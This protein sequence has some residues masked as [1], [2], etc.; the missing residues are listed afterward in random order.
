MAKVAIL[1]FG[2]VGSGV[3]EI[4]SQNAGVCARR[5]GV[6]VEVGYICD[7]R[8]FSAHQAAGLF[9]NNIEPILQDKDVKVVVETIGGLHPAYEYVRAAL[10]SG[11][12]VVTSN[13]ELVAE[14][15]TELMR[16]AKAHSVCFLF[17]ASVGGGTPVIGPMHRDLAANHI[18]SVE[19]IVNGTTNFMLT[20]MRQAGLSFEQ[21]LA[22]A[23]ALGYAET[24]DPSAD[25]D[26]I[27]A[28]R[29]IA[30]LASLAFG[31]HVPPEA[32]PARGIRAVTPQ[33]VALAA[34]LG[35][36]VKLVA[37]AREGAPGRIEA[38][39]EPMLVRNE[40]LLSDVDDVFNAV[41]VR[42]DML[43][44]TVFYGRGAG[45][46][47]TASAVVAD[48]AEALREGA[49][50]HDTLWWAP[51]LAGGETL[52]DTRR[53]DTLLRFSGAGAAQLAA[54]LGGAAQLLWQSEG[55]C[56]FLVRAA[57]PGDVR[58]AQARAQKAGAFCEN[59]LRMLAE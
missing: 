14:K 29:K 13:K 46:L 57:A 9:V 35:C 56:A 25:V 40:D 2:T 51:P 54:A 27:D 3:W 55:Q 24:R 53:A 47:P 59:T 28:K 45:K 38:A 44:D 15:G 37:W 11:R 41:R 52:A 5:A 21:A 39:V 32:V 34:Q 43:G 36:A 7:I 4:L 19:G 22:E 12:C 31:R 33:D 17:E 8:D 23:Q 58:A 48:V 20:R 42:C 10:E 1:G 26:G 16:I 18:L 30:I 6:P 50:V 49:A